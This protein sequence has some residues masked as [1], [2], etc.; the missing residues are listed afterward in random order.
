M[1]S[2]QLS[3]SK[4]V[5]LLRYYIAFRIQIK[6][7]LTLNIKGTT[8]AMFLSLE[9]FVIARVY[10]LRVLEEIQT[11]IIFLSGFDMVILEIAYN[12]GFP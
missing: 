7:K 11:P 4:I 8:T 3:I 1:L 12:F 10:V 9:M 2:S 6:N 5:T